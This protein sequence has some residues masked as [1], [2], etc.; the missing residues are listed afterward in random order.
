M[1]GFFYFL[2]VA[3]VACG[4][5]QPASTINEPS[6]TATVFTTSLLQAQHLRGV[7]VL[8]RAGHADQVSDPL[9]AQTRVEPAS[10]FKIPNTLIALEANA[11]ADE[12]EIL[13]W[14][15]RHHDIEAWNS[16]TDLEHAIANSTVWFYQELARRVGLARMRSFVE[17]FRYGNMQI[18]DSVD[19]FW[20][21]GPLL[22]SAL[23]QVDFAQRLDRGQLPVDER[24]R[25]I[26]MRI[27]P[28]RSDSGL[29]LH[30]KT[31][32]YR[33]ENPPHLWLVGW[34]DDETSH[35]RVYFSLL[36]F[37]D[38]NDVARAQGLRWE[39]A[40]ALLRERGF[41]ELDSLVS[42]R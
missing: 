41:S 14:D 27:L 18:G 37:C 29:T 19:T 28:Q 8:R 38:E 34:A 39:L 35:E 33:G 5:L 10:T 1:R 17:E 9:L 40:I 31:G 6:P 42:G 21:R 24:S 25:E 22:I 4:G 26:L 12:Q 20:L 2:A 7:F 30:A 3:C 13:P 15:G 36:L 23:E 11:I 16:D 32:S